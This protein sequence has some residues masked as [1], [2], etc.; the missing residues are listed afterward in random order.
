MNISCLP[1]L[2]QAIFAKCVNC[3]SSRPD[4]FTEEAAKAEVDFLRVKVDQS[5]KGW[6]EI[7]VVSSEAKKLYKAQK[8][9]VKSNAYLENA[10]TLVCVAPLNWPMS[11]AGSK[12]LAWINCL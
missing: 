6:V 12:Y 5:D 2:V 8:G 10:R 3:Y 7:R 9:G 11:N 4:I 1:W